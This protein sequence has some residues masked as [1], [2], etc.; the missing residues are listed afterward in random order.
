MSG[1]GPK[2]G[3]GAIWYH[4]NVTVKG[5]GPGGKAVQI[6]THSANP[7]APVGSYSRT[8][9]TTQINTKGNPK[10]YRLPDGSWKRLGDMTPAEKAAAH[11]PA[12]N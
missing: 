9:Y 6:R 12:G 10:L 3:N 1:P 5:V 2:Q 8:N 4:D 11:Y 7:N